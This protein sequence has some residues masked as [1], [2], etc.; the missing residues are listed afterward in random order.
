L[1]NKH[2]LEIDHW[3]LPALAGYS[4]R[5][6]DALA[7]KTLVTQEML[8]QGFLAGNSVYVCTEHTPAVVDAYFSGLDPVFALIRECEDGREIGQLLKGPVCHGGFKRLN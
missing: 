3:G 1:A 5:G 8:A 6:P 2:G 7:Y 4:F